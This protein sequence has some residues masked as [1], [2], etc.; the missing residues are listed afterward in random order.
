MSRVAM[1]GALLVA[2]NALYAEQRTVAA[3]AAAIAAVI[4]LAS[5]MSNRRR[6]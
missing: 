3:I 6:G 5:L 2:G 4:A 1:I